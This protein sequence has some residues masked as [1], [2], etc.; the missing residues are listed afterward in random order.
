[1]ADVASLARR[2]SLLGVAP[3][4]DG[5]GASEETWSV[6]TVLDQAATG[7]PAVVISSGSRAAAVALWLRARLDCRVVNCMRPGLGSALRAR[8]YDLAVVPEHD[9]PPL[10]PNVMPVLG[11][12]HRMSPLRLR[13]AAGQWAERLDYL[14]HPRIALL[15]GGTRD[16]PFRGPDLS[17]ALAHTLARKVARMA[18]SRGGS[19]LAATSRRTGHE[20]T[21]AIGA[22]L[23]RVMHQ[24]YRWG[25]PGEN[26]YAGFL[27]LADAIV[28]TGD[29]IAMLSEACAT[30]AP[31]FVAA[32][33]LAGARQKR[34]IAALARA[35]HVR[36]LGR[37]LTTWK[38]VRLDEAGR[39]A[40]EV[41]RRFSLD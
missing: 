4:A 29:S 33:E 40:E 2:G 15:V 38:R 18:A 21:E 39:V 25:E 37:S 24:L 13:H 23:G 1:M 30:L 7:A 34:L 14:P 32:P 6:A 28:V 31:V 9:Q 35:D 16:N 22:G 17:P 11:A 20:A 41:V 36:P 3:P 10:A 12:P 26:P 8:S 5:D 27:A 19:V